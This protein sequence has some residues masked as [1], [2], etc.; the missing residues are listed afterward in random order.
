MSVDWVSSDQVRNNASLQG[1]WFSLLSDPILITFLS[2]WP[3]Y[4]R[5]VHP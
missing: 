5:G 3:S 1:F 4:K 2:P